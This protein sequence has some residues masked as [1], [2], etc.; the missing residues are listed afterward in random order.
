MKHCQ[1][2]EI[3]KDLL[4]EVTWKE[5]WW[6]VLKTTSVRIK[7][8]NWWWKQTAILE[9][10]HRIKK[11]LDCAAQWL[12]Y[13][14]FGRKKNP[15]NCVQN[16]HKS[17]VAEAFSGASFPIADY[18]HIRNGST[19]CEVSSYRLFVDVCTAVTLTNNGLSSGLLHVW[20]MCTK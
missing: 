15:E 19:C 10:I 6:G 17:D 18:S 11:W 5:N 16:Y 3:F 1:I 13:V 2:M 20:E 4:Q 12:K 9:A 14:Y 7:S 8:P